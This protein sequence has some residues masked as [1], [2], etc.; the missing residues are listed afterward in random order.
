M[1]VQN[2]M[3]AS[4]IQGARW[5]K[6]RSSQGDGNCVEVAKLPSGMAMRNSRFPDGSA[7]VYTDEE[8]KR[9]FGAVKGGEFDHLIA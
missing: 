1:Q 3:A 2:G 5:V 9:F 7:L 8:V 6:A 4:A